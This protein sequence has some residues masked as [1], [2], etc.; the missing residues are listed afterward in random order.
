MANGCIKNLPIRKKIMLSYV[1]FIVVISLSVGMICTTLTTGRLE[2]E[3]LEMT[4]QL[5]QQISVNVH[6]Q[7]ESLEKFA[8]Q[9]IADT[10]VRSIFKRNETRQSLANLTND[11]QALEKTISHNVASFASLKSIMLVTNSGNV[12][13]WEKGNPRLS[14]NADPNPA[15]TE[16]VIEKAERS[17]G[18]IAW[19][20]N[21][22]GSEVILAKK[23]LDITTLDP[24]GYVV[25]YVGMDFFRL[26][27]E[28]GDSIIEPANIAILDRQN[29]LIFTGGTAPLDELVEA[30]RQCDTNY[31]RV[32][33]KQYL[34]IRSDGHWDTLCFIPMAGIRK[35]IVQ[36]WYWSLAISALLCALSLIAARAFSYRLTGSIAALSAHMRQVESG[37]LKV[38]A[39]VAGR[40]EVG[41]LTEQFNSMVEKL[42]ALIQSVAE[43]RL[44]RQAMAYQVLQAQ[45]NPHFLYNTIGSI[46]CLAQM[47]GQY[48]VEM[49]LTALIDLMKA[50]LSAQGS[51][52][53]LKTELKC[54]ESFITLQRVRYEDK[55]EV[56]FDIAEEIKNCQVLSFI[57]QPLVENAF[58]HGLS[59]EG[60]N[61]RLVIAGRRE[62]DIL[63]LEVA[64]NGVGMS[65]ETI[66]TILEGEQKKHQAVTNI[67][68]RNINERI[69]YYYG[70]CYGVS[71]QSVPGRGTVIRLSLPVVVE[72][73]ND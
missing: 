57:L 55:F 28:Q 53:S 15:Q 68:I 46:R 72:D 60:E 18:S 45:I 65:Q 27:Y 26:T 69:R 6:Y 43:E 33:A 10:S 34:Y 41:Q 21:A 54:V 56:T 62:Q 39:Q 71:I 48:D 40:D 73:E 51:V 32:G 44:K 19:Q 61:N 13:Y 16:A 36:I 66:A 58:L 37:N 35:N 24:L 5:I 8:F 50:T 3:T 23:A 7:A 29:E 25:L 1:L 64:D 11:A 59:L 67:G 2:Q 52:C 63:L 17:M 4:K 9:L 12:F 49:M 42:E 47:R 14:I 38:R 20:R 31:L 22:N 30:A 70:N